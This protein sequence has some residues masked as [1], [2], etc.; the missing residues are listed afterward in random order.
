MAEV[1]LRRAPREEDVVE[2]IDDVQLRWKGGKVVHAL[3][4]HVRH[5]VRVQ[6]ARQKPLAARLDRLLQACAA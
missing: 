6:R 3:Q 2:E 5:A 1:E 4:H